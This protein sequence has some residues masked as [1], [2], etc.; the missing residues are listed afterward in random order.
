MND[1]PKLLCLECS[2][3]DF[4]EDPDAMVIQLYRGMHLEIKTAVMVCKQC[5][6]VALT[7]PQCDA[8]F[9]KTTELYT[10]VSSGKTGD[11]KLD[12]VEEVGD[13]VKCDM[14]GREWTTSDEKG[15]FIYE[16]NAYC[17]ACCV[18]HLVDGVGTWDPTQI[19][20]CPKDTSFADWIRQFRYQTGQTQKKYYSA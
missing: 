17:P 19:Q 1:K 14:C 8:L 13:E 20:H 10:K 15:G 3:E 4:A 16:N 6:W 2:G 5:G 11:L 7:G 18:E 12:K 9:K